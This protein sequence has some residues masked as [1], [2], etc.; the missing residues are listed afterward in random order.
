MNRILIALVAALGLVAPFQLAA[1]SA[2]D[3]ANQAQSIVDQSKG[4][5]PPS[6]AV[7]AAQSVATQKNRDVTAEEQ[8]AIAEIRNATQS[9]MAN[10][11]ADAREIRPSTGDATVYIFATHSILKDSV[12]RLIT[13]LQLFSKQYPNTAGKAVIVIRGLMPGDKDI[14]QTARRLLPF[15]QSAVDESTALQQTAPAPNQIAVDV[16]MDPKSW[17]DYKVGE[18]APVT[19]IQYPSGDVARA[20]GLVSPTTVHQ[21]YL[22]G[23]RNQGT[24]GP[25]VEVAERS[26]FEVIQERIAKLDGPTLQK[27][28]VSR[29]WERTSKP[30][31]NLPKA[32]QLRYREVDLRFVTPESI[33]DDKGKVLVAAGTTVS[34]LAIRPFT[35]LIVVFNP[36]HP[37]ELQAVQKIVADSRFP[38]DNLRLIVTHFAL[39][40]GVTGA[41]AQASIEEQLGA[42][43]FLLDEALKTRFDIQSTPTSVRGDNR[44]QLLIVTEHPIEAY[45]PSPESASKPVAFDPRK[46]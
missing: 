42:R 26:L 44:R 41:D 4:K 15:I 36:Q 31:F 38:V 23:V 24:L 18:Q 25:P 3:L 35:R 46:R 12:S 30:A 28:A 5:A 40:N 2:Q 16:V 39:P 11:L 32:T 33:T 20:I 45:V 7:Q 10:Q 1:Q 29:F 8:R 43:V 13:D 34:P 19:L 21:R 22:N 27:K 9:A 37:N 6:R 17:R 14:G